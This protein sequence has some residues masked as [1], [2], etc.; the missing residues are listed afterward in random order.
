VRASPV[1]VVGLL[2]AWLCAPLPAQAES[3]E[4]PPDIEVF[5]RAGCPHC[6]AAEIFLDELRKERPA[7]RIQ[8][9]EIRDD[10]AARARLEGLARKL[11]V[12]GIGVP[13]FYLRGGLIIGYDS[14][15]TTGR[16]IR[17]V[18]DRPLSKAEAELSPSDA[19]GIDV[20]FFGRV[21]VRQVGLPLFTVTIGLL[22]GF[23]P[24]SMWVL[25]F[26]ISMLASLQDRPKM[27]L[28]A[29]TFVAVEG[30]AYFA[31]MAAWLNMFLIVGLSRATEL[32]LGGIAVLAGAINVKD[33]RAF[34]R[35]VSLGIPEAAKPELYERIR[36]ILRAENLA[37]ALVGTVILAV[38]VQVVE[39]LCTAGFPAL[40]TRILTMRHLE[41]WA[42]Y[43]YLSLYNVAY[44]LDDVIVLAIGVI[45][46][47]RRR[48]QEK[49]GRWLKL[50]SGVVMLGL[51]V[52][53]IVKPEWL[54]G[55]N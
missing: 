21:T 43:G 33:F 53:L 9:H 37:A 32:A 44:M 22:D 54:A 29:G 4:P 1:L 10:P 8:V 35:G 40:Y 17:A 6:E 38:L 49:E 41:G 27:L 20:P 25:V 31:F 46:L 36:G 39:L 2:T 45:T 50:V 42:Y 19:E 14:E 23:N 48:L 24:C 55:W 16:R 15:E 18:L 52:V 47:S 28:I 3:P 13:A 11:S 26:M 34:G 51:G 7:L 12:R 5:V 30:L